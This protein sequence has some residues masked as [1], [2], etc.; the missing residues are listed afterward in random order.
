[1]VGPPETFPFRHPDD[2]AGSAMTAMKPPVVQPGVAK[3]K[4]LAPL[5]EV[6]GNYLRDRTGGSE[7]MHVFDMAARD[8][9]LEFELKLGTDLARLA[10]SGEG[11]RASAKRATVPRPAVDVWSTAPPRG[12]FLGGVVAPPPLPPATA[13]KSRKIEANQSS[14]KLITAGTD[15]DDAV[16]VLP[17]PK[18]ERPPVSGFVEESD[19]EVVEAAPKSG[20][21]LKPA[22][23]SAP[24]QQASATE[25]KEASGEEVTKVESSEDF[26]RV[27]IEAV[28]RRRNP[29][30]LSD[31]PGLLEKHKGKEM[32]LYKK[33]CSR[34]DLN[35]AKL[36]ADPKSWESEDKD[37]KDDDD[38]ADPATTSTPAP[39]PLPSGV[40]PIP[41]LFLS[42]S[43]GNQTSGGSIFGATATTGAGS[44]FG[45]STA[46]T[47]SGSIFGASTGSTGGSIFGDSKVASTGSLFG[48]PA[49][50]GA[51]IFGSSTN[52]GAGNLFGASESSGSSGSLFGA[53]APGTGS[54]IFS[55]PPP[56]ADPDT[57]INIFGGAT[58]AEKRFASAGGDASSGSLFGSGGEP[59][60]GLF[61]GIPSS[62]G[63][64]GLPAEGASGGGLLGSL[65]S[66]KKSQPESEEKPQNI[67]AEGDKTPKHQ[68]SKAP[69]SF[70]S[71]F[72]EA[73]AFGSSKGEES[74]GVTSLSSNFGTPSIF[75]ATSGGSAF[76]F[77]GPAPASS[78]SSLFGFGSG[79]GGG[80]G[81]FGTTP[82]AEGGFGRQVSSAPDELFDIK[83]QEPK[84]KRLATDVELAEEPPAP[85]PRRKA[86]AD[87][88]AKRKM[89]R[90]R[91]SSAAKKEEP[92]SAPKAEFPPPAPANPQLLENLMAVPPGVEGLFPGLPG[93][94]PVQ[95]VVAT[96]DAPT[97]PP[98]QADEPAS[99]NPFA[100]LTAPEPKETKATPGPAE[101]NITPAAAGT[102][103]A[104][105]EGPVKVETKEDFWR[106][107]IEAIYRK[108]NPM[109]LNDV[110]K[111][112]EKH[113]GKEVILFKKVC[114]RYDLDLSK[115]Y[116]NEDAWSGE[117]REFKD[118]PDEAE[119]T[120]SAASSGSLFGEAAAPSGTG[121][122]NLFGG[123]TGSIF[124][125][126][127]NA[128]L[129]PA[130][131]PNSGGASIFGTPSSGGSLW[132]TPASG[133]SEGG[134]SAPAPLFGAP[135]GGSIFGATGMSGSGSVGSLFGNAFGEKTEKPE[136]GKSIFGSSGSSLFG[137]PATSG[138]GLFGTP[139]SGGSTASTNIF[140]ST[141]ANS[142]FGGSTGTGTSIFGAGSTGS[143]IFGAGSGSGPDSSGSP[144]T[145]A[146]V[147]GAS[148]TSTDSGTSLFGGTGFGGSS[149]GSGTSIFG[150]PGKPAASPIFA[151]GN[152]FAAGGSNPFA[153]STADAPSSAGGIFCGGGAT[154]SGN[155]FGS[156][157]SGGSGENL[158]GFGSGNTSAGGTSGSTNKKKRRAE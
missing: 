22:T 119:A 149:S 33:V 135:S 5:D 84:S 3:G 55:I 42:G 147:F 34:Y 151:S 26:W 95:A 100:G 139:A 23:K 136:E 150:E 143:S 21:A 102:E 81:L 64:F 74:G 93:P 18:A 54:S 113:K 19:V 57:K 86:D 141:G 65:G 128:S 38:D 69:S 36:Y 92:E 11:R 89:V 112:M 91:R 67:F 154:T 121:V 118:D 78:G 82:P 35:P 75:D 76:A 56:P 29:H 90:A 66:T 132:G 9:K 125:S 30:K 127:N 130:P 137:K 28:Y 62:G 1:M 99:S 17:Q 4:M 87:V 133:G 148:T 13:R 94:P 140:G 104:A 129:M 156:N 61:A 142:L 79:S 39:S 108:R 110:P 50:T 31:V 77:G 49:S 126:D 16:E 106:V 46:S 138:S 134:G 107:Q 43:S 6:L 152:M 105:P 123:T 40:P 153:A 72:G 68:D 37:V 10:K 157:S 20:S 25:G 109:K 83:P 103:E 59:G 27:Q 116:T 115:I 101:S 51:G 88:L 85:G 122:P 155:I 114:Q 14:R 12:F 63:L 53:S 96:T 73:P 70:G 48:T 144:A 41:S 80:T 47:G 7:G 146:F 32:H 58:E 124:G 52:S 97:G 2:S 158:F 117:D 71:L 15:S 145:S 111:L 8:R 131:A 24:K 98:K 44:L 45:S 120:G 60:S